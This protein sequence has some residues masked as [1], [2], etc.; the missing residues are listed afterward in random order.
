MQELL[1][2]SSWDK[3]LAERD[4]T[5]IQAVYNQSVLRLPSTGIHFT[6]LWKAKN[7]HNN[8][9]LTT[10]IHNR[11]NHYFVWR[12]YILQYRLSNQILARHPFD[13][14]SLNIPAKTSMPWTFIFPSGTY[15]KRVWK[16]KGLLEVAGSWV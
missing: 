1:F 9:L 4:R 12:Q 15:T 16:E 13:I 14:S 2:E 8:L 10:L 11:N 7:H 6:E 3:N 5:H